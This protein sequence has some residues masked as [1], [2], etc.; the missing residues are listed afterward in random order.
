MVVSH[1]PDIELCSLCGNVGKR[2][3]NTISL[4]L[5]YRGFHHVRLG[6]KAVHDQRAEYA[7]EQIA[8]VADDL[9]FKIRTSFRT[10][11]V[12]DWTQVDTDKPR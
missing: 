5:G 8:S 2:R 10:A 9:F 4:P 1:R 11:F 12:V 3:M 7:G 6:Q